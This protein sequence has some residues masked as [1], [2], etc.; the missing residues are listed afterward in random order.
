MKNALAEA[1]VVL[2]D[3][4]LRG[5]SFDRYLLFER[6]GHRNLA[7]ENGKFEVRCVNY[8][9]FFRN[10]D[11]VT[12]GRKVSRRRLLKAVALFRIFSCF[13][14]SVCIAC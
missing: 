6:G 4:S 9:T 13:F 8:Q 11:F 7:C 3:R 12:Q 1:A 10:F 2:A 5:S 14:R